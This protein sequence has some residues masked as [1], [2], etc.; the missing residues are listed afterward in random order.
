[1]NMLFLYS[2]NFQTHNMKDFTY[3]INISIFCYKKYDFPK[4]CCNLLVQNRLST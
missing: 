1:M 3:S 2:L 4:I